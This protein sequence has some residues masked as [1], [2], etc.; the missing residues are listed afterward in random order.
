MKWTSISMRSG[1]CSERSVLYCREAK[2]GRDRK[3]HYR[4]RPLDLLRMWC[5]KIEPW[6]PGQ[7]GLPNGEG[8]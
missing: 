4:R 7:D 3:Q 5:D 8:V 1:Y 6:I 2:I